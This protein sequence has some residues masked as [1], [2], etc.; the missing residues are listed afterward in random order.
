MTRFMLEGRRDHAPAFVLRSYAMHQLRNGN[1]PID[2][3]LSQR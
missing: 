3:L 1:A 2:G